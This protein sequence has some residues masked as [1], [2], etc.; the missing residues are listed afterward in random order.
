M[1]L[2]IIGGVAGGMSAATRARRLDESATIIVFERGQHVSFANCGLPYFIGGVISDRSSLLVQTP[3]RLRR[4][5]NLDVR[6]LSEVTAIDCERRQV[7]VHDLS[8]ERTY[9]EGYDKLIL[10]PGA[11]PVRP[12]IPG[13]DDPHVHALRTIEDMEGIDSA[14]E[15]AAGGRAVVIGGGFIGLEMA[16]NLTKRGLDV[17]VVETLPQV[18][19]P[20]DA[21]MAQIVH[22]HLLR[23]GVALF[24][25]K[26]ASAI[27]RKG[28][29]LVVRLQD[30]AA[31][32]CDLVVLGAGVRPE[33]WLAEEAGLEIGSTGGI[34]VDEQLRT[35][36]ADIY[37]VG[38]A[39]QVSDY[40]TGQ[41]MLS[42]LAGLANRQGRIAADNACGRAS[43][44]RGAQA[45]AIVKVFDLAVACTGASEKTLRGLNM[46]YE[47]VYISPPSHAWYYP[48]AAPM[49]LKMLFSSEDGRLLGAQIIGTEGV[50]KRIDVFSMALQARMTVYD[51]EEAELAYAPAYGAGNDAANMAGFVAANHLRGDMDIF[52]AEEIT[53]DTA[54]LDV[55]TKGEFDAGHI[56]WATNIHVDELRERLDEAPAGAP[57][58]VICASGYRSY[59][60]CRI[61]AQNG[62][63]VANVLGGYAAYRQ[64]HPEET[65]LRADGPIDSELKARFLFSAGAEA[66]Q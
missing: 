20:L 31:L 35:S 25:G 16:E 30:G 54:V 57:L 18:M 36:D 60:A 63:D 50:D 55:R 8:G 66:G 52:P 59:F 40:V 24:L 19:A 65:E 4:R 12:P 41:P 56:P 47:K 64:Y 2:V 43:T 21:E 61:L 33:T 29:R 13:A 11:S 39:I 22:N 48:G 51:L 23:Q 3:E 32:G 9:V 58:A 42:P 38:D 27:E 14:V 28:A 17:A 44:F 53:P 62:L 5:F 6:T 45:T 37:A 7:T 49:T 1:K 46:P 26:S 34:K 10:A 15:A